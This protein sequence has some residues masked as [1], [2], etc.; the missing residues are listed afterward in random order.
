MNDKIVLFLLAVIFMFGT[1]TMEIGVIGMM[2][3]FYPTNG[4]MSFDAWQVYHIGLYL[5]ILSFVVLGI[6]YA[7]KTDF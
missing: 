7:R 6:L 2:G 3:N 5:Q 1:W 4:F